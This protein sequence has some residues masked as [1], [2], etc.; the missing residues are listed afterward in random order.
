[1]F[2]LK[3]PAKINWLLEVMGL[4]DDGYHEIRSLIQKVTLYDVLT[5]APF[6]EITLTTNSQIPVKENLV[7]KAATILRK[8]YNVKAG[9]RIHLRKYIPAGAGLGGGSSDAATTLIGLN[10]LWGLELRQ[11]ELHAIAEMLGSDVPFFL[12]EPLS[13]VSGRGE[14]ISPLKASNPIDI[15]FVKPG[16][17]VSTA[18][19]YNNLPAQ[20]YQGRNLKSSRL[21]GTELTKKDNNIKLL[22]QSLKQADISTLSKVIFNDLEIVTG[23]S[24]PVIAAIKDRLL[25]EGAVASMMSGSGPTVFGVFDSKKS[26]ENASKAFKG[27]YDSIPSL[28]TA[29]VKTLISDK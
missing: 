24:F 4:R 12:Y 14:K 6:E 8:T 22:C 26:A 21:G 16:I 10:R 20:I 29:V 2:T 18:W 11:K 23:G 25:K 9:A 3:A 1:M 13:L 7:F 5:F 17:T 15:L 27:R 19:A 28:W